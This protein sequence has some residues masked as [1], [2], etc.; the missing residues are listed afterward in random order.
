MTRILLDTMCGGLRPYLRM[1]G[2]DAAYSLDRDV[3]ADD[4]LL[5]IAREEDRLLVTRDEGLAARAERAL[6]LHSL[7][8]RE[9]LQELLDAGVDLRLVDEPSHCGRCNGL[10]ERVDGGRETP[11]Y[12]PDPSADRVWQC[13]DCGQYFWKGSHWDEVAATLAD[14]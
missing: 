1:C 7:D 12:A 11:E 8:V 4:E 6:L 13:A 2:H 14:L 9:Q 5:R 3:E 10:L